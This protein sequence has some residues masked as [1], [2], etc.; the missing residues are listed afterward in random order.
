MLTGKKEKMEPNG[1]RGH[2][3]EEEVMW[4]RERSREKENE[5]VHESLTLV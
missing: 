5:L 4:L 3:R 1:R 2:Q